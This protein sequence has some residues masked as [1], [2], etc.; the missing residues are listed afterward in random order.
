MVSKQQFN[1]APLLAGLTS[2]PGV[3]RMLDGQGAIIYVG[4]ARNLRKRVASYFRRNDEALTPKTRLMLKHV[5]DVE[6]TVTN[7]E[8]EALILEN[9]LI[10]ANKPRYNVL[11]RDDKSYPYIY[12]STDHE[13]PRLSFY[14]GA[15]SGPGRYFGP[16]PGTRAV[17][18]SLHHLQ[19]LFKLRQCEDSFYANRSRPCLQYQI[20]RC[21]APCVGF[22]KPEE[23]HRDVQSAVKFLEGR[24]DE[25][26]EDLAVH[27]ETAANS[28]DYERAAQLRDQIALLNQA[29]ESQ[30]V[31]GRRGINCDVLA[32]VSEN[33]IHCV[34]V[35]FIRGGRSLGHRAFFP[36]ASS[37]DESAA[38]LSAFAAQYYLGREA[39]AEIIVSH[40]L[41]AHDLLE[42]TLSEKGHR[43]IRIKEHVRGTRAQWLELTRANARQAARTRLNRNAGSLKRLEEVARALRLEDPPQRIECFDIS[44]TSGE[45]TV[46]SCVV[47]GLD[48]PIKSDYRKFNISD[49]ASGDDYGAMRQVLKRRY[50]RLKKGEA[51]MPD[52]LIVDGGKGQISEA[53]KILEELQITGITVLGVAKGAARK[54]GQEKLFLSGH[55]G[56]LILPPDSQAL[57]L[58]QQVRDEAHRFAIVGHRAR[59][60]KKRRVSVLESIPGLGPK[61]RRAL[62]RQFGGLQSLKRAGV[63]DLM[64]VKGVSR[65]LARTIYEFFH[66]EGKHGG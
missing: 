11:L 15:R 33:D 29:K 63:E 62:L 49:V 50:T 24:N 32:A 48:G 47:F 13:A 34:S 46:A 8:T 54:P 60:A 45:S 20:K 65:K 26:I 36:R 44:H 3:Y 64:R 17:R 42:A 35:M 58:I 16:F 4:K 19:K 51:P 30:F 6:I 59:R 66:A 52:L 10:K 57:H 40:S 55:S 7:T 14:R 9:N 18:E 56:A 12:L 31:V 37:Q 43:R 25:V 5:S 39:P 2:R 27:M 38:V 41:E 22:I 61:R 23:Y 1:P 28:L 21:S 53:E